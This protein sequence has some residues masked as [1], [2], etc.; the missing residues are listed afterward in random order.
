MAA[1]ELES[2]PADAELQ[3]PA[4]VPVPFHHKE[5]SGFCY[6]THAVELLLG[7]LGI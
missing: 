2:G 1:M 6:H 5:G 7:R 4:A 3:S